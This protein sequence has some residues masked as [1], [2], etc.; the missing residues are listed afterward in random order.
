MRINHSLCIA[1]AAVFFAA[2]AMAE[3]PA[4]D[5]N[6]LP[7]E[8]NYAKIVSRAAGTGAVNETQSAWI[9]Y[10]SNSNPGNGITF[11]S[12]TTLFHGKLSTGAFT[13]TPAVETFT[14]GNGQMIISNSPVN[15]ASLWFASGRWRLD[16]ASNIANAGALYLCGGQIWFNGS[17]QTYANP[18]F[19]GA[20]RYTENNPYNRAALR[21]DHNSTFTAPTT[22]LEPAKITFA[23]SRTLTLAELTGP[24]DLALATQTGNNTLQLNGVDG[25]TGTISV[26]NA[27]TLALGPSVPVP[28][29]T[30]A[31]GS[32]KVTAPL[33]L[34]ARTTAEADSTFNLSS[35]APGNTEAAL[36]VPAGATLTLGAELTLNLA[37]PTS[38]P[39]TYKIF[40]FDPAA[41]VTG[42]SAENLRVLIG[43]ATPAIDSAVF[44]ADG[45]ITLGSP[46]SFTPPSADWTSK[47]LPEQALTLTNVT[48]TIGFGLNSTFIQT[49]N[50]KDSIVAQAAG[51]TGTPSL[52]GLHPYGYG[53]GAPATRDIWLKASGGSYSLIVGGCE[54]NWQNNQFSPIDGSILVELG[55]TATADNI[56]G[57]SY[58]GGNGGGS[59]NGG[60]TGNIGVVIKDQALVTGSIVGGGTSA[61]NQ[62]PVI[63]GSV[64]VR[65][66]NL[67]SDNTGAKLDNNLPVGFIFG[68]SAWTANNRS[69][70][71]VE[72]ETAVTVDLSPTAEGTFAKTLVGGS[73]TSFLLAKPAAF[74]ASSVGS[75][76]IA[77]SAPAAVTFTAP[78][79]GGGYSN[80]EVPSA[81]LG[82][83]SVTLNGGT[84]TSSIVAGGANTGASVGGDA[85]LIL[86]GGTF[87]GAALKASEGGATIAGTPRLVIGGAIDLTAATVTGFTAVTVKPAGALKGYT[88][89]AGQTVTLEGGALEAF[90]CS[91]ATLTA[92]NTFATAGAVAL[93]TGTLNLPLPEAGAPFIANAGDLTFGEGFTVEI[94]DLPPGEYPFAGNTGGTVGGAPVLTRHGTA[95][96]PGAYTLETEADGSLT[97]AFSGGHPYSLGWSTGISA[98]KHSETDPDPGYMWPVLVDRQPTAT[99]AA[100]Q[101]NDT[102]FFLASATVPIEGTVEPA[103]TVIAPGEGGSVTLSGGAIGGSGGLTVESGLA[104]TDRAHT[105]TGVTDLR[106]G[107]TLRY[108]A[109]EGLP[110]LERPVV[111]KGTVDVAL[112]QAAALNLGAA[113]EGTARIASGSFAMDAATIGAGRYSFAD[114]VGASFAENA[115]IP[116]PIA[117]EG[118]HTLTALAGVESNL[119]GI[120]TGTGFTKTGPGILRVVENTGHALTGAVNIETGA[121]WWGIPGP[122]GAGAL[123]GETHALGQTLAAAPGTTLT[124]HVG[125]FSAVDSATDNKVNIATAITLNGATLHSEDGS[126][127]FSRGITATGASAFSGKWTKGWVIE[128]L[129]GGGSFTIRRAANSDHQFSLFTLRGEGG[130]NGTITLA[131][132]DPETNNRGIELR[133]GAERAAAL[134][135]ID[136][137]ADARTRLTLAT[138]QATLAGLSGSGPVTLTNGLAAAT[139]TVAGSADTAFSGAIPAA[140]SLVKTGSGTLTLNTQTYPGAISVEAGAGL[141]GSGT[142]TG[143]V[144]FAET[145]RLSVVPS[146]AATGI[147]TFSGSVGGTAALTLPEGFTP[148]SGVKYYIAQGAAISPSNLIAPEGTYLKADATGIFL[149]ARSGLLITIK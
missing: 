21:M 54:N 41:T 16:R 80:L 96:D 35:I 97:L 28:N 39:A 113:F 78:I 143:A 102:A 148:E 99:T 22:I 79:Y 100:F 95:L 14:P 107:A 124:L 83:T 118:A 32:L 46:V 52:F 98:W 42:W 17:D 18:F 106:E 55:G 60:V 90:T 31:G 58:K 11:R 85:T 38:L 62:I 34:G 68:G 77:V 144:T 13:G 29:L 128:S 63:T 105:Y 111:G 94:G 56:V 75:A 24:G 15:A 2:S 126:Y 89:T 57:G 33:T 59:G 50:G 110:A 130:F 93:T 45:S 133:L 117:F 49:L 149:A 116:S 40:A 146:A 109:P 114:G 72:G 125:R 138:A 20:T 142:F 4:T 127:H 69:G 26:S 123:A 67:Q 12:G 91:G 3:L 81:V 51:T 64:A 8:S 70:T 135:A 132:E 139:L 145:A 115:T 88:A 74:T 84:Y 134:A 87:T 108:A 1:C 137:G 7:L 25:Y 86:N 27:V 76:A 129:S 101:N 37:A 19:L 23:N 119:G 131:S 141:G 10:T 73:Y 92:T 136:T 66:E 47:D 5:E 53:T 30:L 82:N 104:A 122:G 44:N 43:G 65:I 140:V 9:N 6:G 121:F 36:T 61:H 103:L 112:A 48:S 71:I 147:A 120:L